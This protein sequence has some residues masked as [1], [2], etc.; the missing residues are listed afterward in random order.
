MYRESFTADGWFRTGDTGIVDDD[1]YLRLTGRI[2]DL[3]IR[4]G[5]VNISPVEIENALA[6]HPQIARIA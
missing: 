5:G 6:G 2:K 4:G 1:G 3:I